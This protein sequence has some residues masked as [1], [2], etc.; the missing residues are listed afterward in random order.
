M[1]KLIRVFGRFASTYRIFRLKSDYSCGTGLDLRSV[2]SFRGEVG[3]AFKNDYV[4]VGSSGGVLVSAGYA[5]NGCSPKIELFGMVIGTPEGV[6]NSSGVPRTYYP[7]LIH[8][9]FYQVSGEVSG[10]DRKVVDRLFLE[11]LKEEG[12]GAAWL[13]YLVVRMFGGRVWGRVEGGG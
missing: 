13:Y 7:S 8:D 11:M 6:L 9:V 12:F 1:K 5:W 10:L 3:C 4:W 2:A